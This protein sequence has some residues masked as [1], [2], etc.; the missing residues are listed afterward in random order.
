MFRKL[1]KPEV[2]INVTDPNGVTVDQ[3]E[4]IYINCNVQSNPEAKAIW[5]TGHKYI[6]TSL[7]KVEGNMLVI[8]KATRDFN[9]ITFE[10]SATNSAGMSKPAAVKINVLCKCFLVVCSIHTNSAL[11]TS[12]TVPP[13]LKD[14]SPLHQ[15]IQLNSQGSV[16]CHFKGN[17]KPKVHWFLQS[18]VNGESRELPVVDEQHSGELLFTNMSYKDAGTYT[19][20]GRNYNRK[21]GRED[22]Q[23]PQSMSVEVYGR[24]EFLQPERIVTASLGFDTLVTQTFCSNPFPSRVF[25]VY[26]QQEKHVE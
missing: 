1:V 17:P 26:N 6:S 5:K 22:R 11:F 2:S 25:W 21:L 8:K 10:C 9:G 19:C 4:S 15:K 20:D 3:D 16:F 13:E 12:N 24:P 14:S 7:Y 23:Q 18:A